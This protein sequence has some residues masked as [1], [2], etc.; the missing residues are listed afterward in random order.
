MSKG[1][2]ARLRRKRCAEYRAARSCKTR[3]A[4]RDDGQVSLFAAPA[5][6]ICER[7]RS[8]I[9][10]DRSSVDLGCAGIVRCE[11]ETREAFSVGLERVTEHAALLGIC[12]WVQP[13]EG[14]N[15]VTLKPAWAAQ[16]YAPTHFPEL[17]GET[18]EA[19]LARSI[20]RIER[21]KWET[22]RRWGVRFVW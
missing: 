22:I 15:L 13:G 19:E 17:Q 4:P 7:D 20:A 9:G 10:R 21:A 16:L 2:R 5:P 8:E 6:S 18:L 12:V 3:P 1:W 14:Q 11:P